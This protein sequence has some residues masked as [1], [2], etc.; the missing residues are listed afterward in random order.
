MIKFLLLSFVLYAVLSFLAGSSN[1]SVLITAR[2]NH[3]PTL[4]S[5]DETVVYKALTVIEGD[6]L[7]DKFCE[8]QSERL[9]RTQKR[10]IIV[11]T[12]WVLA[13]LTWSSSIYLWILENNAKVKERF[14][15][16]LIFRYNHFAT[17]R[18]RIKLKLCLPIAFSFVTSL[19]SSFE[20][21]RSDVGGIPFDEVSLREDFSWKLAVRPQFHSR[22]STSQ[23][24]KSSARITI[25]PFGESWSFTATT[26]S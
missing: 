9:C 21:E 7:V 26:S 15:A 6:I 20:V 5:I 25:F 1:G 14:A 8:C 19:K 22:F 24:Q 12:K 23:E 13:I 3:N 2:Q 17:N 10:S 4:K 18:K 16:R 11:L